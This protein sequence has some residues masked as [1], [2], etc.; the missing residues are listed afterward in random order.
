M[1]TT[2]FFGYDYERFYQLYWKKNIRIQTSVLLISVTPQYKRI[3][4]SQTS[5]MKNAHSTSIIPIISF[6]SMFTTTPA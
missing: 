1:T 4:A 3:W 5:L 6:K 2:V